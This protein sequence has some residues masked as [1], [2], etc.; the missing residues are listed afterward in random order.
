MYSFSVVLSLVSVVLV[1]TVSFGKLAVPSTVHADIGM[2]RLSVIQSVLWSSLLPFHL[3]V[4][5]PNGSM[6]SVPST[7][8]E[9][10]LVQ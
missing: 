4:N 7:H 6:V 3:L 9:L 2:N 8:L 5:L 10:L 1:V